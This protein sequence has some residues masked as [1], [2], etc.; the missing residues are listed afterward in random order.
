MLLSPG[1]ATPRA[2]APILPSSD[3]LIHAGEPRLEYS[4]PRGTSDG[5]AIV[6]D[7]HPPRIHVIDPLG[8][9]EFIR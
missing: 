3:S 4:T 6:S 2:S 9:I 5:S 1:G 7:V 8:Y